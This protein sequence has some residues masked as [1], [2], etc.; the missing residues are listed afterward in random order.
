M[1]KMH[2]LEAIKEIKSRFPKTRIFTLTVH[3]TEEYIYAALRAAVPT[4]IATCPSDHGRLPIRVL[5]ID[6]V[7]SG[8]MSELTKFE[9]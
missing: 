6:L 4:G 1:P 2:G 5:N 8:D 7:S 3:K 9:E